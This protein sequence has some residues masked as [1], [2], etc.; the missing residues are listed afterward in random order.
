[1]ITQKNPERAEIEISDSNL[2]YGQEFLRFNSNDPRKKLLFARAESDHNGALE[3][4]GV[5]HLFEVFDK[6]YDVR[7]QIVGSFKE[8]CDAIRNGAKTGDLEYIFV[9]A[10]GNSD[11]IVLY[12]FMPIRIL[13]YIWVY[14]VDQA[15]S[16]FSDFVDCFSP[17]PST[18]KI[19]LMSC[20]TGEPQK[21]LEGVIEKITGWEQKGDPF[22]NIAQAMADTGKRVVYAPTDL[23]TANV[24]YLPE[25]QVLKENKKREDF[26]GKLFDLPYEGNL[27][28]AFHPCSK[29]YSPH[30]NR[31]ILTKYELA[32]ESAIKADL[33]ARFL[34][35]KDST[36]LEGYFQNCKDDLRKKVVVVSI[37]EP[38]PA[39]DN[40]KLF[41][42]LIN[43]FDFRFKQAWN[44]YDVCD[45]AFEAAKQGEVAA[46]II[47]VAKSNNGILFP[48]DSNGKEDQID[49][50]KDFRSCF[51][52]LSKD[53]K[54]IFM[55]GSLGSDLVDVPSIPQKIADE[56]Q[57]VVD[58]SVCTIFAK[59]VEIKSLEPL[60][61]HHSSHMYLENWACGCK[62]DN[63]FKSFYLQN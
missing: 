30:V 10:H 38:W 31:F 52:E 20:S 42:D 1:M 51:S 55:D 25:N 56:T 45:S 32:T 39:I 8:L 46:I 13:Q 63:L 41:R 53:T 12:K 44:F 37:N 34:L 49:L 57:R 36:F 61:L 27:Y 7:Y 59:K 4:W 5:S 16:P 2:T 18:A 29:I 35:H 17:L 15:I 43:N 21:F 33:I 3:P 58:A 48:K 24:V 50:S 23:A 19:Y 28:Q 62:G 9:N 22:D 47:Q 54:I 11:F 6:D 14:F 60:T 40:V 26:F